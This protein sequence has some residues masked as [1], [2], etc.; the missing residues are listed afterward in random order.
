MGK[1]SK[2]TA[3]KAVGSDVPESI[4]HLLGGQASTV[5][6]QLA[7]LFEQSA[8]PVKP[9]QLISISQRGRTKPVL[10]ESHDAEAGSD[11]EDMVDAAPEA[12]DVDGLDDDDEENAPTIPQSSRKRKRVNEN[13]TLEA[14]YLDRIAKQEAKLQ[15]KQRAESKSKRLKADDD[16]SENKA[17]DASN[18]ESADSDVDSEEEVGT[19]ADQV[20]PPVHE[21]LTTDPQT[22][23]MEKASRTIFLSNV[24]TEAI[25]S[26]GAKKTLLAHLSSFFS[27]LAE[28]STPHSIESFR[29][30]STAFSTN[31]MPK[32]AAYAKQ[33][34]MDT[35]TKSTNA[36]VVYS[37]SAAARRALKLN[38]SIVLDR[39]LRVD[40]VAK[41]AVID[42]RRCVFVGNLGFVD[43]ETT[44][45]DEQDGGRKRKK[46]AVAGD[47]EEGLWRTFNTQVAKELKLNLE[48]PGNGPVESVRV[49]RDRLTRIGKGFAY[50]QFKDENGVEAALLLDGKNFPPLLPRKLRV[51][52]A[53]KVQQSSRPLEQ[54]LSNPSAAGRTRGDRR[55]ANPNVIRLGAKGEHETSNNKRTK[56]ASLAKA[57]KLFGRATAAKMR[58]SSKDD[59]ATSSSQKEPLVFEGHRAKGGS[60]LGFK[61]KPSRKG[62][63]GKPKTRS[64][65]RAKAFKEAGRKKA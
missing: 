51:S 16:Q 52:R 55:G 33:E 4:S 20:K 46:N 18:G 65:R 9:A 12:T 54:S 15:K 22:D 57:E 30:R 7:S 27:S 1:K 39:H 44:T 50:V 5:D 63:G 3:E 60:D 11:D 62:S 26:K 29:F 53:N 59:K 38:G 8:G 56:T 36:Y 43:Q 40:S 35:T 21:S 25:K 47:V 28:T 42:H 34:L 24:S 49:V 37:T 17:S 31:S 58:V 48:T 2:S 45:G 64:A 32:R 14:S 19:E 10:Q 23:A 41:P 13:D 61:L 6:P